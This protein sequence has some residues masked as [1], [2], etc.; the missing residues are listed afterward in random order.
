ML[1]RADAV[2]KSGVANMHA[3]CTCMGQQAMP[4]ICDT[5]LLLPGRE[6]AAEHIWR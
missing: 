6:L 2:L 5:H 4:F 1:H 3:H